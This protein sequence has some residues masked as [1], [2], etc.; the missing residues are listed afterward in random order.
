MQWTENV[1]ML[2]Q[3]DKW[4]CQINPVK[5][6]L[7]SKASF[8]W[9]MHAR[10]ILNAYSKGQSVWDSGLSLSRWPT[11]ERSACRTGGSYR[12]PATGLHCWR[13]RW[14]WRSRSGRACPSCR[15]CCSRPVCAA[16]T[17]PSASAVRRSSCGRGTR[18]RSACRSPA[19]PSSLLR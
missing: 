13:T 6:E 1:N 5:S 17:H 19:T 3:T 10:F 9:D 2:A 11:L 12:T 18:R 16:G 14:R 15:G 7:K 4:R 8:V